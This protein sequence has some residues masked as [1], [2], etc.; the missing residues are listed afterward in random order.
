MHHLPLNE[1]KHTAQNGGF[2]LML[3]V[4]EGGGSVVNLNA[5]FHH[6]D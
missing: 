3:I 4:N 1:Y 5:D 2:T 6:L